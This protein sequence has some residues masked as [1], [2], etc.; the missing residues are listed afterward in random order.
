MVSNKEIHRVAMDLFKVA[1]KAKESGEESLFKKLTRKAF[2]FEKQAAL[3]LLYDYKSE[4]TRSV[5][6]RSAAT[7]AYNGGLFNEGEQLI[8]LA[9]AGKPH[10]EI[11]SELTS[12]RK[13]IRASKS[14]LLSER[15]QQY[16]L[17]EEIIEILTGIMQ[18]QIHDRKFNFKKED[19]VYFIRD[20]IENLKAYFPSRK[21]QIS[22]T[23][24]DWEFNKY[25]E[26][27]NFFRLRNDEL[28][29]V[30]IF[31]LISYGDKNIIS[32]KKLIQN[33]INE[34]SQYSGLINLILYETESNEEIK[35][36]FNDILYVLID[37]N[38][39]S[40][41]DVLSIDTRA[42]FNEDL[43]FQHNNYEIE[44]NEK[45]IIISP[46]ENTYGTFELEPRNEIENKLKS[47]EEIYHDCI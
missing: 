31:L 36:K 19:E 4:P 29:F 40:F 26:I 18:N 41:I 16:I 7:M 47:I 13:K 32:N 38:V 35:K 27:L 22:Q 8:K 14:T 33:I 6:F 34:K 1:I 45:Q 3:L 30:S 37:K 9:L 28:G 44:L 2:V 25:I 24:H 10:P 17:S 12:L 42:K 21:F 20:C 5:L 39:K 43:Y 11:R 46:N 23:V 15:Q